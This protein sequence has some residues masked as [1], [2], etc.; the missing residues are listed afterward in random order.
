VAHRSAGHQIAVKQ[1]NF[2]QPNRDDKT[3]VELFLHY[4]LET[5][6]AGM[7]SGIS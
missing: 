5:A 7:I 2:R 4:C 3:P 1:F 6:N